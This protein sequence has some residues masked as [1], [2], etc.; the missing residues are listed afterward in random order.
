M[1]YVSESAAGVSPVGIVIRVY[2]N[3]VSDLGR[4]VNAVRDGDIE[5][6]SLQLDH[7]LLLIAHLESALDLE[8]GGQPAR[9]LG[10]FYSLAR[11]RIVQAQMKQSGKILEEIANDFLSI[12]EAWVQVEQQEAAAPATETQPRHVSCVA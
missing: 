5:K 6:R 2:E 12:R 9:L 10:K 8:R 7:A 3:I 11:N 1:N 4:A